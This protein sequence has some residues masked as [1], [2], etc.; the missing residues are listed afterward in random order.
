[1]TENPHMKSI[2]PKPP[3]VAYKR[4]MNIRDKL[5]RAKVPP[6][7]T[8][9]PKRIKNGM[10]KCNKPCAICPYVWRHCTLLNEFVIPYQTDGSAAVQMK[11]SLMNMSFKFV[12]DFNVYNFYRCIYVNDK[13]HNTCLHSICLVLWKAIESM[14]IF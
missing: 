11:Y 14:L 1:M 5:I 13:V 2:F 3:L 6:P 7:Q 8:S 4:P 9:R 10:A 12:G